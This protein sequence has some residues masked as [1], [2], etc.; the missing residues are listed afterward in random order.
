MHKQVIS[1]T[2]VTVALA[3]NHI[4]C[5]DVSGSMYY[6][7][8]TLREALKNKLTTLIGADDKLSIIYF[9]GRNDSDFVFDNYQLKNV[10]DLSNVKKGIDRWLQ[11]IGA[12]AFQKPLEL[13]LT[14]VDK[15]YLNNLV[16]MTDGYNNDAPL[17]KVFEALERVKTA[18][19]TTYF[20]EWGYYADSNLMAKM[21]ETTSG[22]VVMAENFESFTVQL[23]NSLKS[24]TAPKI[25]VEV[26]SDYAFGV[27]NGEVITYKA[28]NGTIHVAGDTDCIYYGESNGG[29]AESLILLYGYFSIGRFAEAEK[30]L[31]GLGDL[32]LIEQYLKSYGKQKINAFKTLVLE[33]IRDDRQV[34]VDGKE[35]N[36]VIDENAYTV[37]DLLHDLTEGNNIVYTRHERFNYNRI[38]AKRAIA[39]APSVEDVTEMMKNQIDGV[40]SLDE[41]NDVMADLLGAYN[42]II[43]TPEFVFNDEFGAAP[44]NLITWNSS[45]AN[46]NMTV[47][48]YGKVQNLPSNQWN[49]TEYAS[50]V[51]RAYT[52]CKDGILNL[53]QLP[54][55]LDGETYKKLAAQ[56]LITETLEPINGKEVYL[57]DF[58]NLPII[59]RSMLR[60]LNSE[61]FVKLNLELEE[62]KAAAKVYKFYNKEVNEKTTV[63][64]PELNEFLKAVGITYNGFNPKTTKPESTDVYYAPVLDCKFVGLSS[65]PA[66]DKT[67]QKREG[68]KTLNLADRMILKYVDL[69]NTTMK[70][71][72]DDAEVL[73]NLT[74]ATIRVKRSKEYAIA[75]NVMSLIL[76]RG[77]FTDKEGF[78]DNKVEFNHPEFGVISATLQYEDEAVKI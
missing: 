9:S 21:A 5:V 7:L 24:V 23:E 43:K 39:A 42:K 66:V 57:V 70:A 15:S 20:I 58:S 8:P 49:L 27:S 25:A 67:I 12:T 62:S 65:L 53:S 59:N 48:S 36:Y 55:S 38:G 54:V 2:P 61:E 72:N 30:V 76:S 52:I 35:S 16:F 63:D 4:F 60:E 34:F 51:T 45:R 13:A 74:T 33:T 75:Q 56:N 6:S 22:V 68:G 46:I 1:A 69:Y 32:G 3:T 28:E 11:P 71:T 18:F 17:P 77:W 78:E 73:N 41:L 31:F 47:K 14:R 44:M 29:V 26:P 50:W 64:D 40:Q 37:L 10:N 19:D